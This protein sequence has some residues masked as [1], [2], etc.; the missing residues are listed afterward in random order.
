MFRRQLRSEDV[1]KKIA[2][3]VGD[4]NS[5][6]EIYSYKDIKKIDYLAFDKDFFYLVRALE[7]NEAF[8][9]AVQKA[10]KKFGI[11]PEGIVWQEYNNAT[12][13]PSSHDE[14][15]SSTKFIEDVKSEAI[16]IY[17]ELGLDKALKWV[18]H[19]IIIA[20]CVFSTGSA[21]C[22]MPEDEASLGFPLR[23]GSYPAREKA[24]VIQINKKVNKYQLHRFIDENW[25]KISRELENLP[26]FSKSYVS[27]RDMLILKLR[28]TNK[29]SYKEIADEIVKR[30][31]LDDLDA[32]INEDSVKTAYKRA[33]DRIASLA[34]KK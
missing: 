26:S 5:F 33:R 25:T 19:D 27:D 4:I 13:F 29:K 30:Y 7:K 21:I 31:K 15:Q 16:K 14:Q 24:T 8:V 18:L 9:H 12:L 2:F 17:Q 10:R 32:N 11:P 20:N 3:I 6:A 1:M 22:F 28:D 23:L 34:R